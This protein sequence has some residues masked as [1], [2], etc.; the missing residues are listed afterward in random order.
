M[1]QQ[2]VAAAKGRL[3]ILTPGMGAVATTFY[4]GVEAV[5]KELGHPI[6]SLTQ[7]G[8]LE[9]PN[10]GSAPIRSALPVAGLQ[11]LVLGGWDISTENAYQVAQ[12]SAVLE[13]D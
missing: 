8:E 6:G 10:G 12:R 7:M 9:L 3:G 11:D 5:K 1:A 4:A 13:R 2:K